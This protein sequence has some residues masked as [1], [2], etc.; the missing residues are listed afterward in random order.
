MATHPQMSTDFS[1]LAALLGGCF[2]TEKRSFKSMKCATPH[3]PAENKPNAM[4]SL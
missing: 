1:S 4:T 2:S 3:P